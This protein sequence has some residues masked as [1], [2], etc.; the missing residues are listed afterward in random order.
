MAGPQG[1]PWPGRVLEWVGG[2]SGTKAPLDHGP[3]SSSSSGAECG[4]CCFQQDLSPSLRPWG[5]GPS[6][7]KD[8][9]STLAPVLVWA[10]WVGTFREQHCYT[11][12]L[13]RGPH[14]GRVP[15]RPL[16]P[17]THGASAVLPLLGFSTAFF[18]FFQVYLF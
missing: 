6:A 10:R 8:G 12:G 2:S 13:R 15:P 5:V 4:H 18:F 7:I 1:N 14:L 16:H 9:D 11:P 3:P 17:G